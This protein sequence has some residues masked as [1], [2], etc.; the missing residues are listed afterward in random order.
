MSSLSAA[1]AAPPE[2]RGNWLL[3]PI[4]SALHY[5]H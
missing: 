1:L 5:V 2:S 4:D 3:V